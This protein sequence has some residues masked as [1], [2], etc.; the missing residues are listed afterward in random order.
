MF[1]LIF[2]LII[3][4]LT[5][6]AAGP[7]V[8]AEDFSNG[9]SKSVGTVED[10]RPSWYAVINSGTK[11]KKLYVKGDIFSSDKYMTKCLRVAEIDKD[12]LLLED[13]ASK[14]NIILKPGDRIPLEGTGLVFEKAVE[15]NILEYSYKPS[16]G[17]TK[18]QAEDFTVKGLGKKRVV[19]EKKYDAPAD[20][21]QKEKEIFEAPKD[22][23]IS[24]KIII[25][26]L[27][28]K[29]EVKK[30]GEDVWAI[31]RHAEPAVANTGSAIISAIRMVE[32]RYRF[33]EGPSL[34]FNSDLGTVV[35]NRDGFL[36]QDIAIAELGEDFGICEGDLIKTINGYPVNNLLG[37]YRA[38]ES[39]AS[40]KSTKLVSINIIRD[41]R[42]KTLVY[43]IR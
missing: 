3:Y 37:I 18:A 32:P 36:V 1:Y 43:K 29:I 41:G 14:D 4:I 6:V 35:I 23:G 38:F 26:D 5:G 8:F 21:T 16:S 30:I 13:V 31:N 2:P 39:V 34:K 42:S 28:K 33:R 7:M 22:A 40:D 24:R 12:S 9:S 15:A 11:G 25:A 19:L 20:L 17:I 27:F 10:T